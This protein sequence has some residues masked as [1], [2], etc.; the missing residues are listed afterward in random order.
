MSAF[1]EDIFSMLAIA[2]TY[3]AKGTITQY[4]RPHK[5]S[6][7]IPLTPGAETTSYRTHYKLGFAHLKLTL[8]KG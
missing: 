8:G 5:Y 7:A 2:H 3:K 1:P 6:D 4:L